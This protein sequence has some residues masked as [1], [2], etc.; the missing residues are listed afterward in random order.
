[1]TDYL[2]DLRQHFATAEQYASE[3]DDVTQTMLI[4]TTY[5]AG[6]KFDINKQ[7]LVLTPDISPPAKLNGMVQGSL[8]PKIL[9]IV[10]L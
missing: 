7:V 10:T 4:V 9:H 1:V 2:K 6:K 5:K 3:H 8:L